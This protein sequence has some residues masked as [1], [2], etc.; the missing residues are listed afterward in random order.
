MLKRL[1]D[2]VD[3]LEGNPAVLGIA[4]YGGRRL[5]DSSQ[6]G[7]FDLFVFLEKYA[8]E[9]ESIHFY[10]GGI[11][12]DMSIRT[13]DCLHHSKPIASIDIT[14]VNA[15]ILYDKTGLLKEGIS[16]LSERWSGTSSVL[17][18]AWVAQERF[19][20]RHVLE[21]A[22]RRLLEL[23]LV[24]ELMLATNIYWLIQDYFPLRG[25]SYPGGLRRAL[26]WLEAED[27]TVYAAIHDFFAL[28][29]LRDKLTISEQLTELI[30]SPVGGAWKESEVLALAMSPDTVQL[31]SKGKEIFRDLFGCSFEES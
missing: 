27:P 25:M 10:V 14:L 9:V 17:T 7:D 28:H 23:P 11:P 26:N 31:Q 30:L 6:G 4:R 12:V 18:E 24:C 1:E 16:G 29:D 13:L 20:R 21:K 15:E 19:H 8:L 3:R 22:G 5:A 2:L